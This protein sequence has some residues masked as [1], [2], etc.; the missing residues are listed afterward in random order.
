MKE[1]S[2]LGRPEGPPGPVGAGRKLLV[3]GVDSLPSCA[4]N[5]PGLGA[6][7][8]IALLKGLGFVC[9]TSAPGGSS[10]SLTL[11]GGQRGKPGWQCEQEHEGSWGGVTVWDARWWG[12]LSSGVGAPPPSVPQLRNSP[13][14]SRSARLTISL[15]SVWMFLLSM[16]EKLRYSRPVCQQLLPSAR[17]VG[18]RATATDVPGLSHRHGQGRGRR[19]G[20]GAWAASHW[21]HVCVCAHAH[22]HACPSSGSSHF[23]PLSPLSPSPPVSLSF[24]PI[25]PSFPPHPSLLPSLPLF[26]LLLSRPH[27][28]SR[29]R[30]GLCQV[31][32]VILSFQEY[33]EATSGHAG[34]FLTT[35][36]LGLLDYRGFFFFC[37]CMCEMKQK[38]ARN[39]MLCKI[40]EAVWE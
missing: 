24:F 37:M 5:W 14:P 35:S 10:R 17:G 8:T 21:K 32:A 16:L 34:S 6:R 26:F 29:E 15:V 2:G 39:P 27:G 23:C 18:C 13:V 11:P 19:R 1:L 25:L 20:R 40:T 33:T 36:P 4:S 7:G 9:N 31:P 30:T 22:T 12:W 38:A 3:T 28:G